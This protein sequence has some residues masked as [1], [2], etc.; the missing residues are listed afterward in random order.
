M[1]TCIARKH[2]INA[3]MKKHTSAIKAQ[4]K[5]RTALKKTNKTNK[6]KK[7]KKKF[8]GIRSRAGRSRS[9]TRPKTAFAFRARTD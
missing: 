4:N 3:H 9:D 5:T 1:H 8:G 2:A 6:K 7:K